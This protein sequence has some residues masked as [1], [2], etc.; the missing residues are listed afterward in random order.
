M[1]AVTAM[2]KDL[3]HPER[4]SESLTQAKDTNGVCSGNI[5]NLSQ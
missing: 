2:L 5:A 3:M 1:D 4:S